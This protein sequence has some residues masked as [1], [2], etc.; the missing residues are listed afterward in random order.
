MTWNVAT[1]LQARVKT[2][3]GVLNRGGAA[4]F[5]RPIALAAHLETMIPPGRVG[6]VPINASG[7]SMFASAAVDIWLRA[8]HS[9][10]I[11]A[12]LTRASPL[13]ASVAGY[14]SSHYSVRG[15]AHLLGFFTL[16]RKK[17]VAQFNVTGGTMT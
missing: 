1:A 9:L 5:P 13:W 17:L 15:I 7:A 3:F 12:A 11:S 14:Y 4:T 8:I 6:T 2:A 16:H 10:V